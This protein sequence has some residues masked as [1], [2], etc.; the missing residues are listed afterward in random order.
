MEAGF[1]SPAEQVRIQSFNEMPVELDELLF[2][3]DGTTAIFGSAV[4]ERKITIP[5]RHA[6]ANLPEME[7]SDHR[8]F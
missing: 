5:H 4:N 2:P 6:S 3:E 1:C 7:Q 8:R